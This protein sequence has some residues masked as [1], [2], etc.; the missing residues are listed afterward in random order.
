MSNICYSGD[1]P[2]GR[3]DTHHMRNDMNKQFA[4]RAKTAVSS[5]D[6]HFIVH[7][8]S[9]QAYRTYN[10][11]EDRTTALKTDYGCIL[12]VFDGTFSNSNLSK[13]QQLVSGHYDDM[14]SDYASKNLIK[15]VDIQVSAVI[16]KNPKSLTKQ[17]PFVSLIQFRNSM[18]PSIVL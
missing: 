3:Y 6:S 14:V 12:G 7:Q 16:A 8:A 1:Y 10:R 13:Y 18:Q 5:F 11:N 17:Y 4:S 15:E 9:F 2:V